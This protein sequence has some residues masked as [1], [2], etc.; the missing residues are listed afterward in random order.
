MCA[1]VD[2]ES[3]QNPMCSASPME[4][5][6]H[7]AKPLNRAFIILRTRT[8][9]YMMFLTL[10]NYPFRT[11]R[12]GLTSVFSS[13]LEIAN[14]SLMFGF[15]SSKEAINNVYYCQQPLWR[16]HVTLSS[17]PWWWKIF[18]ALSLQREINRLCAQR[19][20]DACDESETSN[21]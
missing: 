1:E 13:R 2:W 8:T 9:T 21:S 4:V 7:A 14:N 19:V 17:A 20:F 15:D 10:R 11:M 12:G 6:L 18:G 5:K 3:W 16:Y